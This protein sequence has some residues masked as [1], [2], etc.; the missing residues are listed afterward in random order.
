M[1][2]WNKLVEIDSKYQVRHNEFEI[3]S[4]LVSETLFARK[5]IDST[6]I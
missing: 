4:R 5:Q 6:G 1:T 3:T 2:N